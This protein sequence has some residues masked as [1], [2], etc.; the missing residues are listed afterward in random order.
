LGAGDRFELPMH[1]AYETGV[2]TTLPAKF[3][4]TYSIY[5]GNWW[6]L[7]ESNYLA[8]TLL[9]KAYRVTAG[10]REQPPKNTTGFAF[11]P[12]KVE[13]LFAE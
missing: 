4:I 5:V 13:F 6:R 11:F 10:N 9:D 12:L 3:I 7:E 2:V 8:T 1:L